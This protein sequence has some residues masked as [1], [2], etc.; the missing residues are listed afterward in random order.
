MKGL[1]CLCEDKIK[2]KAACLFKAW[3]IMLMRMLFRR[4]VSD[5]TVSTKVAY[6]FIDWLMRLMITG[7]FRQDATLFNLSVEKHSNQNMT[8][9]LIDWLMRLMTTLLSTR[10]Q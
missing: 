3:L 8:Y 6:L 4:H 1:S 7:S 2:Q 9:L 10:L 5:L